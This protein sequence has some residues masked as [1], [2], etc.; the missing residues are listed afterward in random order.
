[1]TH[2]WEDMEFS[3]FG[4]ESDDTGYDPFSLM[5]IAEGTISLPADFK[6]HPRLERQHIANRKSQL[7]DNKVDWATA[8]AMALG[9]LTIEG[10]NVRL[11]G[12]D[13]ERG[14]FSQRHAIFTEQET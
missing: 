11:V 10:H 8:E 9:S 3:I 5:R 7:E 1:M 13:S 4:E 6:V 14:T 12:Q 2:K